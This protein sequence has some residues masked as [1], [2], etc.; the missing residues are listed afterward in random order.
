[1]GNTVVGVQGDVTHGI[2][3]ELRGWRF[4]A[5]FRVSLVK[6]TAKW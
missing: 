6:I 1:M 5:S 4:C 2:A 3:E